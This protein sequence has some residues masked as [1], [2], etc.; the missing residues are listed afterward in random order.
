MM[1]GRHAMNHHGRGHGQDLPMMIPSIPI[2]MAMF[3]MIV[4]FMFGA[5]IGSAIA[6]KH[7]MMSDGEY[8]PMMWKHRMGMG[9]MGMGMHG[10][11]K[12]RMGMGMMHHHHGD[13]PA[14]RCD[15]WP[16]PEA[17]EAE[18]RPEPEPYAEMPEL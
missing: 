16:E 2:P 4:S 17:V 5:T 12:H 14:C 3:G 1:M 13:G 15:A 18:R 9:G 11:G 6:R 7:A 10:M 8:P